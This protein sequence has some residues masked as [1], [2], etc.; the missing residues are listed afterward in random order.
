MRLLFIVMIFW[1]MNAHSNP[2]AHKCN[3]DKQN[4]S[5][6]S[7]PDFIFSNQSENSGKEFRLITWNVNLMSS[8]LIGRLFLYYVD[9][10]DMNDILIRTQSIANRLRDEKYDIIALQEVGDH[11]SKAILDHTLNSA[12]YFSSEILG[13]VQDHLGDS[14][15]IFNG[16]VTLY[17]Q[18]PFI[19]LKY[20]PF[21]RAAGLQYFMPKGVVYGKIY[22]HGRIVHLFSLHLQSIENN[23][24]EEYDVLKRHQHELREFIDSI[25]IDREDHVFLLGDFNVDAQNYSLKEEAG[26]EFKE[27]LNVL[28][29]REVAPFSNCQPDISFNPSKNPMAK[30]KSP[31]GTLDNILCV[32]STACPYRGSKRIIRFE[33]TTTRLKELS[34]HYPIEATIFIP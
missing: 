32:N 1:V 29:A 24:K 30:G 25:A 2:S 26:S 33:D 16:G 31:T 23:S 18:Y 13:E 22:F 9:N 28:K 20:H 21:S 34:D 6:Y 15:Y 14:K 19:T 27:M 11:T 8:W 7:F 3:V 4:T 10:Q 17:S 12:G 5:T